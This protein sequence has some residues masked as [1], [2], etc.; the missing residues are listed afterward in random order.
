VGSLLEDTD[1]L[2]GLELQLSESRTVVHV[3]NELGL[4]VTTQFELCGMWRCVVSPR[5]VG[6]GSDRKLEYDKFLE[7]EEG[8]VVV[9]L[10]F[11]LRTV[12]FTSVEAVV[13]LDCDEVTL[14]ESRVRSQAMDSVLL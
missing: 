9:A 8:G 11:K 13:E 1:L 10:N 12:A 5:A 7:F 3:L 6:V 2:I 14:L 4:R